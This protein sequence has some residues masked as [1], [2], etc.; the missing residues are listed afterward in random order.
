MLV[1]PHFTLA[2]IFADHMMFQAGK[3]VYL[4]GSCLKRRE[5]RI[6]IN[7]MTFRF[8]TADVTFCFELPAMPYIKDPFDFEVVCQA[9]K[10]TIHNCLVGDVFIV[11]G[12]ANMGF[13][14][15]AT[16]ETKVKE[17]PNIRFFQ[18]PALPYTNAHMEFPQFYNNKSAWDTCNFESAMKFSAIGYLV[19]QILQKDQNSPIGIISCCLDDSSVLSWA[20]IMELCQTPETQKHLSTYRIDYSK[21]PN[22]DAYSEAFNSQLPKW[23]SFKAEM[24][25]NIQSG[26][27]AEKGYYTAKKNH[28]D[29]ELPMGPK[30]H[31]RPAGAFETMTSTIVPFSVRGVMFYQGEAD[32]ANNALYEE[33]FIAMIKSWRRGFKD[34]GLPFVFVQI[35]GY[36]Y[37]GLSETA[38][39]IIREAQANCINFNNNI[40]MAT[41]ADLGEENHICPR[42]KT[43]IA[44]RLADTI[45]EKI[46]K[47]GKNSMAPALFSYQ[48][49]E[50]HLIIYTE[51]NNLNLVSHSKRNLGFKATID[52]LTFQNIETDRIELSGNQIIIK[53][54]KK[55][56][57][58]RYNFTNFPYLDI[59]STND[60][61]LLPFRIKIES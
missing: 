17:T 44:K 26:M 46:Y 51:F 37:P 43:I 19:A 30:H 40:Y 60:L 5:I 29:I 16:Y 28:P 1:K 59:Y 48:I 50:N 32:C 24:E 20:G 47:S 49:T 55:I 41:A 53:D 7:G 3:P 45:L 58:I 33:A 31:N 22:L 21:Y 6:R 39:A 34:I 35:A 25:A 15:Q 54:I 14:L 27:T 13:P 11:S 10:Q 57:E 8:K 2:P 18:V 23:H 4:F 56:K 12:Q 36:S 38:S 9:Q 42:D 61:P 52:E